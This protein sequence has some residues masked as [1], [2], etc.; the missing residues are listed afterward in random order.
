V[1]SS[2][3]QQ[4]GGLEEWHWW[5]RGRHRVIESVLRRELAGGDGGPRRI[6]SV[7]CGPA[8]GLRWLLPFAGSGGAVCGLDV[9]PAHAE[10]PPEGV[11]FVVGRLEEAPFPDGSFDAVFALDVLEHLDDDEAGLREALRLVSP[12]GLLLVTVPA[13]PSLWGGQDVVSEHR[14]RY[15]KGSLARLFEGIGISGYRVSYFNTLLFPLAASVRLAR[16]AAGRSM[17]PRSDF[18]DNRPGLLNDVLAWVFSLEGA[19]VAR[20][21]LPFGVSLLATYKGGLGGG[22][23]GRSHVLSERASDR[24]SG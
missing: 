2:F 7:G 20:V 6:L 17:R 10:N 13:L 16:R 1:K 21:P 3:A 19:L 11:E 8:H 15:T 14:R 12:S 24:R 18:E 22:S 4:Y 9:E 23:D 5:F